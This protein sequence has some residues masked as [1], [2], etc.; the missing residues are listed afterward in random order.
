MTTQIG[1]R[2]NVYGPS[3]CPICGDHKETIYAGERYQL[4]CRKHPGHPLYIAP[5]HEAEIIELSNA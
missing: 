5:E 1:D 3:R 4:T 2:L